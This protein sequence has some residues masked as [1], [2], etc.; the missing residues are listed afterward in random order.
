MVGNAPGAAGVKV[1]GQGGLS[2]LAR[3]LESW[4]G[5][6][7][8]E[9]HQGAVAVAQAAI[10]DQAACTTE[11]P[12]LMALEAGSLGSRCWQDRFLEGTL[13]LACTRPFLRVHTVLVS[14][15]V[16]SVLA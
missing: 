16:R 12:C 13:F 6:S 4:L 1:L 7:V 2:A 15:S 3:G 10:P 14:P 5:E 11:V 9:T 8:L